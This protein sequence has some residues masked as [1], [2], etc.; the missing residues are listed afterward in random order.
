MND[1]NNLKEASL[2]IA[3]IMGM[4]GVYGIKY[5]FSGDP[6]SLLWFSFFLFFFFLPSKY[7]YLGILGIIGVIFALLIMSSNI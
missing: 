6:L 3:P 7:K 4:I 5:F 2:Q 1:I